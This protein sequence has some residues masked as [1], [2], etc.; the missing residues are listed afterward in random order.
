[1]STQMTKREYQ[2]IIDADLEWLMKQPDSLE[3]DHIATVLASSEREYAASFSN[4]SAQS[5]LD[6]AR[7]RI[8]ELE[9]DVLAWKHATVL[10]IEH[11]GELNAALAAKDK[12][13][14]E[15][16]NI[17]FLRNSELVQTN[18]R[19]TELEAEVK[20]AQEVACAWKETFDRQCDD[21]LTLRTRIAELEA[22]LAAKDK[23]E[24]KPENKTEPVDEWTH[25]PKGPKED[26]CVWT[27]EGRLYAPECSVGKCAM[28]PYVGKP[29]FHCGR[30]VV[31]KE[32]GEV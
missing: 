28:V 4:E 31:V 15:L 11:I 18:Y 19:L 20:R 16:E 14:A 13:I 6:E 3:R 25:G 32:K 22:A 17:L 8:A 24:N 9:A 10:S 26:V 27:R 23:P 5:E 29:C 12:R 7:K 2:I 1:M 30:R 21:C